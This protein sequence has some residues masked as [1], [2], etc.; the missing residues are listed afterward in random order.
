[1]CTILIAW[2]SLDDALLVLAGNRDELVARPSAAPARLSASPLIYGGRDLSAGGTW[3][4][5]DAGG[6]VAAVTNRRSGGGDEAAGNPA[7]RSRGELPLMLLRDRD[8]A[9][10]LASVRARDYNPFN[11]VAV[12][13]SRALVGH[14]RGGESPDIT[15]L[16]PGPHV[17]CVHDV[18]DPIHA[19]E[20]RIGRRLSEELAG[21]RSAAGCVEVMT[22]LLGDHTAEADPRDAVCIHGDVYGTVSASVVVIG[23]GGAVRYRHAAGRPCT[24]PF[25]E[26]I[27]A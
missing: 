6:R 20:A 4:A 23:N 22:T 3:M 9:I 13:G 25:E 21:C 15:E 2:R 18:D 10:A 11:L 5:V 14:A 1:M 7:L 19:K 8:L 16:A 24:A 12:E 27:L 17:L 26:V